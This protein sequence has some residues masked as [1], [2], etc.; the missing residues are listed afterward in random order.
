MGS[1]WQHNIGPVVNNLIRLLSDNDY[2]VTYADDT[3]GANF[4]YIELHTNTIDDVEELSYLLSKYGIA[5]FEIGGTIYVHR[6]V[7][8]KLWLEIFDESYLNGIG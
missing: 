1:T 5:D 4:A 7:Q 6:E 3:G 2:I 8:R